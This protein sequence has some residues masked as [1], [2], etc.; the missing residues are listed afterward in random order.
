MK[1]FSSRYS[2]VA[3]P[4]AQKSLEVESDF[5]VSLS[6]FSLT[7]VF[8][9]CQSQ[10]NEG[11]RVVE[12]KIKVT[13]Q[14]G[15]ALAAPRRAIGKTLPCPVCRA[16]VTVLDPSSRTN[17]QDIGGMS[18]ASTVMRALAV[19]QEK[20]SA[21][22][23]TGV[24]RILGDS[25]RLPD[26]PVRNSPKLRECPKCGHQVSLTRTVCNRCHCFIGSSSEHSSIA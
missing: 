2:L 6:N 19:Q 13:C 25:P 26:P 17:D 18:N 23:D 20:Q 9:S 12:E 16:K 21:L 1:E 8:R 7:L 3:W 10:E 14:N 4:W 22:T 5:C 11:A 24:M 15:H